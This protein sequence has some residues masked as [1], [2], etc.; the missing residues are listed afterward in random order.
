MQ[1]VDLGPSELVLDSPHPTPNF[2]QVGLG[3]KPGCF[4]THR[5]QVDRDLISSCHF[6]PQGF[7]QSLR[8]QLMGDIVALELANVNIPVF[9]KVELSADRLQSYEGWLF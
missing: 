5:I 3:V 8:V 7:P 6:G 9:D 2:I 4:G 1:V